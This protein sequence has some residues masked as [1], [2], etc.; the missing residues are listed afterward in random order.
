MPIAETSNITTDE[1]DEP[2]Q[3]RTRSLQDL[4]DCTDEVH[5]VCLLADI[6]DVGFEDA[7]TDDNWRASMDEEIRSIEKNRT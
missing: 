2:R 6:T 5:L 4:Y 1:D 3:P 7:I